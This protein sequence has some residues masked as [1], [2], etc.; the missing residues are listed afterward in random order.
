MNNPETKELLVDRKRGVFFPALSLSKKINDNEELQFSFSKRISRP[1]YTDLASFVRYSDPVAVYSG[2]PLLKSTITNN[3]KIGYSYKNYSLS[4]VFSREEFPIVRYQITQSPQK[5]LLYVSP[6]NLA[7]QNVINAQINIPVKI[8]D[9]W[10]MSYSFTGGPR[11]FKVEHTP[12]PVRKTYFGFSLNFN[13]SFKLPK[14]FSAELS[15]W[16]NSQNYNGSIKAGGIGAVNAAIKKELNNNWGS[17][18]L[19]VNDIF[20]TLHIDVYYGTLTQEVFSI[21]N[22]VSV[23]FE[24]GTFPIFKLSY[25]KSFGIAKSR[26]KINVGSEDERERA[27]N[28]N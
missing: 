3:L 23:N 2:N 10:S 19:A 28:G 6:Q 7:Y 25:S 20:R 18:Q 8:A 15:G 12:V 4:L 24:S 27:R 1:S 21:K 5:N 9:W 17:F 11:Q 22:H 16:Y 14:K 13:Q 26:R